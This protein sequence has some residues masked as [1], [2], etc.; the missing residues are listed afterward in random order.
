MNIDSYSSTTEMTN[1][2]PAI[3][4]EAIRFRIARLLEGEEAA[5][6]HLRPLQAALVDQWHNLQSREA[7]QRGSNE[8]TMDRQP[9]VHGSAV[10]AARRKEAA[11]CPVP[12]FSGS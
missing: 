7:A 9:S 4:H 6:A 10:R 2:H 5:R 8:R 3:R 12:L 11:A 1:A